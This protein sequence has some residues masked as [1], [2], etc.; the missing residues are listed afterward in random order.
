MKRRE[1]I[2]TTGLAAAGLAAAP[3]LLQSCSKEP[4]FQI[5]LA[6]WS[7]HRALSG[8]ML[9]NLEFPVKAKRDFG[10]TAVEYVSTFF[11][12]LEQD[13]KYLTELKRITDYHKVTNLLIMVDGEGNLG[14]DT[15]EV[16]TRTV[17]NH[18]KWVDAALFLGC[19]SI[20]VN[21]GGP[22]DAE[23][24]AGNVITGLTELGGYARNKGIN[25]IVENHGGF[26]SNGKWLSGVIQ[27]VN[28]PNVG[29][30]PDFGN[31]TI[32][33]TEQYDRYL[34]MEELMPFA[35]GVSAKSHDFDGD[36]NETTIDF[37][38][39]IR[40]IRKSGYRGYIDVEYEGDKFTEDEG[41]M[42]TK[43]LLERLI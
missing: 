13:P 18:Q 25:V 5:S 12:D 7:L 8:G 38:R 29:T 28:M 39:M 16:R 33:E 23:T 40:I 37:A 34:G 41:I 24:L 20:R 11:N 4:R 3:G 9:D 6:Q 22:G 32:S 36:G 42:L 35:K 27:K 30:L 10:I 21:A 2:N 31:F 17:E 15:P 26:S 14:E 1:F 19:H 43:K